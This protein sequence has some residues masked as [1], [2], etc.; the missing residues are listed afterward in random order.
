MDLDR[1]KAAIGGALRQRPD[2]PVLV[3][4]D[5]HSAAGK[6]TVADVLATEF[7]AA[8]VAGD[9][10]YRVMS[11]PDRAALAPSEGADR[12]YDWRRM[13][14]EALAPSRSGWWRPITPMSGQLVN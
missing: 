4:V 14:T 8:V 6:S 5:G 2:R 12:Y 7:G 10:F 11:E 3:C 9:G 1:A 13:D